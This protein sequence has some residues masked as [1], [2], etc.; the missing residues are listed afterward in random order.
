MGEDNTEQKNNNQPRQMTSIRGMYQDWFLDYASYVILE[1][2]IPH[3]N[4]GLKPVQRRI[5]HSMHE[6][7]DGRYNKVANIVGNTMKYHPHGDASIGDAITGLGQ[8][9]LM[10]DTQGNWGNI[11]TGDSAA[12]PRYIE[13]RLSKFA[14]ETSFNYRTTTFHPSYDG[15]NQEPDTLPIKFPLL[16][17]Q[18]SKGIAVG[19]ACEILPHNFN[20]LLDASISILKGEAFTLYPDFPTGGLMDVNEYNDGVRGGRLLI[21]ARIQ[22]EDARTLVITE[23]PYST[24]SDSLIESIAKATDSGKLKIKKIENNTAKTAEIRLHLPNDVSVDQT[25]DALYAF[26]DCQKS[27][28]PNS[29]V[30]DN[31]KPCFMP[32]SEILR[33]S[34]NTTVN[35]LKKELELD[36]QDLKDKWQWISLERIFIEN[37]IYE[38][39]KPCKTDESINTTIANGLKPF[40][41]DLIREVTAEDIQR[42]RKIPIDRI[43]RYNSD[44]AD[45]DLQ[46]IETD[47]DEVKNNLEHLTEYSIR[48]FK[49]LKDKYGKQKDRKTEIRNFHRIEVTQAAAAT[50]KLYCNFKDGFAGYKLKGDDVEYVA[51][52]STLD[53][54][55]VVH[56]DGTYI[57]KKIAEKDF[58]G[59]NIIHIAVFKRNDERTIYNI[60]YNNGPYGR[61]F[62]KRCAITGVIR[63]KEYDFTQGVKGSALLY[64][65]ANANGEAEKVTV[66][67]K[68]RPRMRRLSFIFDFAQLAI[69]GRNAHGNIVDANPV[70]RVSKKTAGVSTL[71]AQKIWFDTSIMQLN[72]LERGNLIGEFKGGDKILIITQKG[73]YRITDPDLNLHFDDDTL[74]VE[75]FKDNKPVTAIYWDG[76]AEAYYIKR[77]IPEMISNERISFLN[78][79]NNV[80]KFCLTDYLPVISIDGEQ[81]QVSELADVMKYKAKGKKISKDKKAKIKVLPPLPYQEEVTEEEDTAD[82]TQ[83][84][85]FDAQPEE[86]NGVQG[87]LFE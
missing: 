14:L 25:I 32:V 45:K 48:W 52:C 63:D 47:M 74:T 1:R 19:L 64:F 57:V 40:V 84:E 72:T 11:L 54:I 15:R 51:D 44:K 6:L 83:D 34:T 41:K 50:E 59:K 3:L 79:Q 71:Q 31:Q 4:D 26:T 43:S 21:R 75:K 61:C 35:L 81:K 78:G 13:A 9:E 53:D 27:I 58:V 12:A 69:K 77:F 22:R 66:F 7:D 17:A 60:M 70:R 37:E 76:E 38:D 36:L 46:A 85:F 29:C 30:I 5:L 28:S 82:I 68:A 2:A 49:H 56:Q 65:S 87:S 33:R 18:G 39:I 20:E 42:L 80:L 23:I 24:T 86:E 10:I 16:L 55:I 67:L 8:K 73:T 62:A